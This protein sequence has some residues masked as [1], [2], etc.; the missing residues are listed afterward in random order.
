MFWPLV[1]LV[2]GVGGGG[3][4]R[5]MFCSSQ[6]MGLEN[7]VGEPVTSNLLSE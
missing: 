3:A 7:L 5:L 1:A 4:E 2:G 6:V